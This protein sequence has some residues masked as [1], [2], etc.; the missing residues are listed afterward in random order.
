LG[1]K[2]LDMM[3]RFYKEKFGWTP[4]KDSDGIVFFK[5]NGFILGLFP[6][7]ELAS[8]IGTS[9]EGKGFRNFTMA[10]NFTSADEVDHAVAELRLS[11]VRIVKEPTK[12]FWGR[13]H[14]YI[15]DPEGNY[16]ELAYN[17]FLVFDKT[18]NVDKHG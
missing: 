9:P 2:D 11:G 18:G 8:D 4:M 7:H 15:V 17:P 1:V 13:Y 12:I 3:K 6:S 16:W 5:L 10:I 14:S